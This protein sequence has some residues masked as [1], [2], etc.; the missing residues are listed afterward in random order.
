MEQTADDGGGDDDADDGDNDDDADDD[1]DGDDDDDHHHVDEGKWM[2][3]KQHLIARNDT[4]AKASL[5]AESVAERLRLSMCKC[6]RACMRGYE[7]VPELTECLKSSR[8]LVRAH[9]VVGA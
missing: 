1:G 5:W 4:E 6:V 3:Q 2:P 9:R 7:G 8:K